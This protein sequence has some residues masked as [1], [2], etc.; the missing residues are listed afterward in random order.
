MLLSATL[1]AGKRTWSQTGHLCRP[2]SIK[3]IV[4]CTYSIA[5]FDSTT[6]HCHLAQRRG[7]ARHP[8]GSSQSCLPVKLD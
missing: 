7:E 2:D 1:R 5:A 8:D 3:S 6:P 4:A